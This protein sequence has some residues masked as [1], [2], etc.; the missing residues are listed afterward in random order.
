[1]AEA[2]DGAKATPFG[3]PAYRP[4]IAGPAAGAEARTTGQGIVLLLA[5]VVFFS[6]FSASAKWLSETY[7]PLQIVFFRGFFGLLPV[8]LV[9]AW[10]GGGAVRLISARPWLQAVRGLTALG[11]NICVVF[12]FRYLPLG[13][14]ISIAY[15]APIFVTI[16]SVFLLSER[17][18]LHRW[19]AVAVGFLGILL[20]AQPGVGV[21]H[22][23]AL[24][25][26]FGTVLYAA[27]IIATRQLAGSDPVVCT[28]AW[29]TGLY[30]V[31]SGLVL[32]FVWITPDW[33][34]MA[35]FCALGLL[36][37]TGMFLFVQ[38][39][40][41]AEAST[42]APFDYSS[43]AWAVLLGFLIWGDLPGFG[44][45]SGIAVIAASG[46]YIMVRERRRRA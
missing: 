46:L 44:T 17:V 11:A 37:G 28:M 35:L 38:A 7:H 25:A 40:R 10:D 23:A 41:L 29:S 19:G 31:L 4:G 3:T 34:D 1:M 21:V 18:G 14:A 24:V 36:S 22:P 42:L 43:M 15:A 39:Y 33:R 45:V 9:L 27:S 2:G 32:P 30:V 5:A 20:V 13:E 8:A 6:L 16:L 12:S 26:I